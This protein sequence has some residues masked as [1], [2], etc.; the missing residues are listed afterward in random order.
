MRRRS[1]VPRKSIADELGGVSVSVVSQVLNGQAADYRMSK[2]TEIAVLKA[3][4]RLD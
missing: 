2:A 3:A 4:E 1:R